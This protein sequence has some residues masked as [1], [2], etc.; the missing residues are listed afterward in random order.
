M[1]AA[2]RIHSIHRNLVFTVTSRLSLRF[3]F[4]SVVADSWTPVGVNDHPFFL[5]GF[6]A[7]F[8][9]TVQGDRA[10]ETVGPR[11]KR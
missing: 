8:T 11:G 3:S 6:H 5:A 10:T 4:T 9:V 1:I 2:Q 7:R